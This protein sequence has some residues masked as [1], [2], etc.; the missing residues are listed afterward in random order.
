MGAVHPHPDEPARSPR[1][2]STEAF[3]A[4]TALLR[5]PLPGLPDAGV[6]LP[7]WL[8]DPALREAAAQSN[9]AAFQRRWSLYRPAAARRGGRPVLRLSAARTRPSP[10]HCRRTRRFAGRAVSLVSGRAGTFNGRVLGRA[11]TRADSDVTPDVLPTLLPGFAGTTLPAWLAARL[12]AGLGG[13]CLF[14]GNIESL[15]QLRTLTDAIYA[16]NPRA[17]VA[18]DE[19]GGDVTRLFARQGSP[20][21]ATRC[22]AGSTISTRTAYAAREI[23]ALLRRTG[24]QPGLRAQRRHQ[25]QPRQPGDRRA[26]LR[27]HGRRRGP[28]RRR[29]DPRAAVHRRRRQAKHFPGHGDT[30]Q[31][32][33]LALPVVDRSLPELRQ[34]EL[35]PFVAAIEAGV[36]VVM[37]S[38]ILL[39]QL[40]AETARRP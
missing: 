34:R 38:H 32:S 1:R 11:I 22:S 33:H 24:V 30:A 37:T 15:D 6:R 5:H 10:T 29:L 16:E 27:R 25:L 19:E 21:R 4:A 14:A 23:G 17:L 18:L 9:L 13:V 36:R 40:D 7:S 26:Q 39:P 35:V 12:R 8:L 3:A 20:S 2:A 31:D 28:A